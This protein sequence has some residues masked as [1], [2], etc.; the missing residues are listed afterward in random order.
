MDYR[1]VADARGAEAGVGQMA[2]LAVAPDGEVVATFRVAKATLRGEAGR[3]LALV[4][5][6]RSLVELRQPFHP[7]AEPEPDVH[8]IDL[9]LFDLL[10]KE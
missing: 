9:P 6:R 5:R 1:L 8:L 7:P 4:L 2:V 3:R 10:P